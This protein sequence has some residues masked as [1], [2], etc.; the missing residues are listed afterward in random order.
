LGIKNSKG[1]ARRFTDGYI[2]KL[3]SIAKQFM[4]EFYKGLT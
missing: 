3:R 2:Q 4:E 1:I